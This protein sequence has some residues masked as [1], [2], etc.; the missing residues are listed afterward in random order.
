MPGIGRLT[1]R[2]AR[3]R[4]HRLRERIGRQA[5]LVAQVLAAHLRAGRSLAQAV[6]E[7][8]EHLPQPARAGME[9]AAG[10]VA[11]G[12]PPGEAVRAVGTH[13]DLELLAAALAMQARYGGELPVLLEDMSEALHQRAALERSARVATAQ[14]RATGRIVSV[15]PLLGVVALWLVDRPA[16]ETLLMT[17]VGW[18]AILCSA[19]LT[20]AGQLLI[21]R[22]ARVDP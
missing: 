15:M 3:L 16:A 5:P 7:S 9:R 20:I 17:W 19:A 2:I 1:R 4:E 13:P 8:A 11:L 10:A 21:G 18:I 6:G 12:V 22:I 14:A